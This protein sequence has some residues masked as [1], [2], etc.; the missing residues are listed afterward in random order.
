MT[1]RVYE[2][3]GPRSAALILAHGAG[4]G[5]RSPFMVGFAHALAALGVE[6]ITFDFPYIQEGRR[7]PD[8]RPALEACYRA[9]IDAVCPPGDRIFIGGKSPEM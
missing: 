8:R 3:D 4:A 1:A 6:T 2:A 7:V 9:V 5:Q